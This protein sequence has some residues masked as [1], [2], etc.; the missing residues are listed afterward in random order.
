[1]K[2][3]EV[4]Q[5]NS[6]QNWLLSTKKDSKLTKLWNRTKERT[7]PYWCQSFLAKRVL[8]SHFALFIK[9][10]GKS[11][12][13]LFSARDENWEHRASPSIVVMIASSTSPS[14]I[15]HDLMAS[16][17]IWTVQQPQ[18]PPPQPNFVPVSC[19]LSRKTHSKGVS[20][21]SSTK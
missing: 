2:K 10:D 1:M 9:T 15:L 8:L 7:A 11:D 13:C 20:R 16:P 14:R 12:Q 4:S 18:Y 21:V 6:Y 3:M 5:P 19:I 17:L